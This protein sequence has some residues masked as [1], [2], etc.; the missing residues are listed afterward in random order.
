MAKVSKLLEEKDY[1]VYRVE[2]SE[3]PT[4]TYLVTSQASRDIL[5]NPHIAGK[6]LQDRMDK[7]SEI[8]VDAVSKV[9]LKDV[10]KKDLVEFVLLSGALYYNLNFGFKQVQDFAIPQ[11]FLGIKRER[12]EGT[13]G[14]FRAVATYENFESL[15]DDATVIMGDTI[16]SG[17]TITKA[18]QI[19]FNAAEEKKFK[20]K[21]LIILT[22]AGSTK[23]ARLLK[24]FEENI[25][26]RSP[27]TEIYHFAAE[28]F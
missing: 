15:K 2:D 12:V 11:L 22:L 25:K 9:A 7:M 28:Q 14:D 6:K 5:Y 19:L 27:E 18:L 24:E 8:F 1:R 16:A 26:K 17:A 4:N 21:K 23:G 10:K 20:I 13:E 3:V